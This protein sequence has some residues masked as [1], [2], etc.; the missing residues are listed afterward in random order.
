MHGNFHLCV[1]HKS[2]ILNKK[3]A[4]LS[5]YGVLVFKTYI[6]RS[7]IPEIHGH[8]RY[9]HFEADCLKIALKTFEQISYVLLHSVESASNQNK[10]RKSA[11][12]T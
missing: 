12:S 5:N 11:A 7:N 2:L 10:K 8:Y 3:E 9:K 4:R 6:H 1:I